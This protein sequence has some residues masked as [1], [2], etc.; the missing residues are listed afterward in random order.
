MEKKSWIAA[1]LSSVLLLSCSD[2]IPSANNETATSGKTKVGVEE[3]FK[4]MMESMTYTFQEFY[5]LSTITNVYSH[6]AELMQQ[7]LKDSLKTLVIP[8]KL[9]DQERTYLQSLKL[10]P[11]EVKIAEDAVALIIHPDNK[12]TNI[13]VATVKSILMGLDTT[14]NQLNPDSKLGKINVVFDHDQSGNYRYMKEKLLEGASFQ[15]NVFA[16][17]SNKEVIEYVAQHKS[18]MGFISINHISDKDDSTSL[19]YLKQIK[20]MNVGV[21]AGQYFKPYQA[22]IVLKDYPFVRDVYM[23]TRSSAMNLGMGFLQF[24]SGQKGQILIKLQ[25]MMPANVQ[26]RLIKVDMSKKPLE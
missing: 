4:P 21:V 11:Q 1:L 26:P 12:D 9:T 14:W 5:P 24:T 13:S 6:E 20:V 17:N 25:G 3:S 19:S 10:L 15:K 2:F 22:Y 16:V 7:F 18:A 8:R 23:I